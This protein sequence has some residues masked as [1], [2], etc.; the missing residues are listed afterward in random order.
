[1]AQIRN[2]TILI[3]I[4]VVATMLLQTSEA[5]DYIVGGDVIGWTSFPPGG[6]SFYSKWAAN[7]T[8]KLNDNLGNSSQFTFI[9]FFVCR[10]SVKCHLKFTHTIVRFHVR[11]QVKVFSLTILIFPVE[12]GLIDI[13]NSFLINCILT[14]FEQFIYLYN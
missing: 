10:R 5:E 12:L 3:V 6:D 7:F 14:L 4:I 8:F 2:I 13:T 1:M 9:Y 11:I